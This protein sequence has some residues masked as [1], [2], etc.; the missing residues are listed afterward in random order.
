MSEWGNNVFAAVCLTFSFA[1]ILFVDIM[2]H[3][4]SSIALFTALALR[5]LKKITNKELQTKKKN[6]FWWKLGTIT[7]FRE[8]KKKFGNARLPL[9]TFQKYFVDGSDN[10]LGRQRHRAS[11]V[12]W[13]ITQ[14][15]TQ[16]TATGAQRTNHQT[17]LSCQRKMTHVYNRKCFT[18]DKKKTRFQEDVIR[19]SWK[20]RW[21]IHYLLSNSSLWPP[22][23]SI[24]RS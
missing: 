6:S 1:M 23:W 3:T 9:P 24:R 19:L 10:T 17:T 14:Y 2:Q 20:T 8:R 11:K 21:L 12:S 15:W 22:T 13:P 16:M 4:L 5:H 7:S 18:I